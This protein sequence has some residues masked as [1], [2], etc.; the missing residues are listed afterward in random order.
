MVAEWPRGV[1]AGGPRR[2]RRRA[3]DG[4]SPTAPWLDGIVAAY[5][6]L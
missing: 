5:A 4:A 6:A 2:P 1:N 3:A